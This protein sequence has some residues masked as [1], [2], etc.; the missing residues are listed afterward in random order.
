MYCG[1][2]NVLSDIETDPQEATSGSFKNV[3]SHQEKVCLFSENITRL[4]VTTAG[5][6]NQG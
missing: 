6:N 1:S 5:Y 3:M 4:Q 2:P